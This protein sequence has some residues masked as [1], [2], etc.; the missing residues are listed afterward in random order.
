MHTPSEKKQHLGTAPSTAGSINTSANLLKKLNEIDDPLSRA[1]CSNQIGLAFVREG[2]LQQA[3]TYFNQS[4]TEYQSIDEETNEQVTACIQI[5]N[6]MGEIYLNLYH[7]QNHLQTHLNYAAIQFEQARKLLNQLPDSSLNEYAFTHYHLAKLAEIKNKHQD[8]IDY[9]IKALGVYRGLKQQDYIGDI[10]Y[11]LGTLY[12]T[13]NPQDLTN[14]QQMFSEALTIPGQ[15]TEGKT[16]YHLG[17]IYI[18]QK[19]YL[20]AK[21]AF[22]QA[23]V[24]LDEATDNTEIA[25]TIYYQGIIE[26]HNK[27][28]SAAIN[29]LNRA[30]FKYQTMNE[31]GLYD[32]HIARC[33][34]QLGLAYQQDNN[35]TYA[36][37][38]LNQALP[39]FKEVFNSN[40]NHPEIINVQKALQQVTESQQQEAVRSS[41]V[42]AQT[43]ERTTMSTKKEPIET[44][45]QS[46]LAYLF[47]CCGV[48]A[49]NPKP[50]GEQATSTNP[51]TVSLTENGVT[52]TQ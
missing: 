43:I 19:N 20:K 39:L 10:L 50:S 44:T 47:T 24:L 29:A 22:K 4:L 3:L 31:D 36:T 9:F 11:H 8:A 12:L 26:N 30:L 18:I 27:Q 41:Q 2:D 42:L 52:N 51:L 46:S 15:T 25:D 48:F 13:K 38:S 40:L 17:T 7:S 5:C 6:H 14:A 16:H 37:S 21:E 49:S 45:Q 33:H 1:Q 32:L 35:L 28:P 23:M 34:Y